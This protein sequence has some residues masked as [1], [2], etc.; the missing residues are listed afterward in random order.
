MDAKTKNGLIV[1]GVVLAI[2]YFIFRK[3]KGKTDTIIVN[4]RNNNNPFDKYSFVD[5]STK[6]KELQDYLKSNGQ[7][8]TFAY[9]WAKGTDE[10]I[11]AW[12]EAM[13]ANKPNFT[14]YNKVI[15]SDEKVDTKTGNKL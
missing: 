15:L 14:F 1:S 6:I 2:V 3:P 8:W 10:G 9:T 4:P 5:K 13:K 12:Y 7:L 11:N